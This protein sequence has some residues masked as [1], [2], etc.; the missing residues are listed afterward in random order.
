[1]EEIIR[2]ENL[3]K[4]YDLG[5]VKV[6][7]LR[8]ITMSVIRGEF[9]AIMGASGSGK[10]TFMNILGC[11]DRLT[12][13][14]YIL[15]GNDVSLLNNDQLAI[16]RK[17]KIGFVFQNFNLLARSSALENVQLPMIYNRL[18]RRV[19]KERAKALI[20]MVGLEGREKNRPSQLSGGEQQRVA[21]A[22][23]LANNPSLI[24]ADEPTGNLDSVT[25]QEIINIFKRLHS[26]KDVTIVLITHELEIARQALRIITFKDGKVLSDCYSH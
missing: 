19:Q 13:G 24:L 7:V 2:V 15:E 17:Q 14:K 18:V 22:R 10:S 21:I 23:A 6:K 26:E 8:G 5:Q 9:V 11:L 16:I 3:K 1:M 4:D 25:T 20:Q 12:G